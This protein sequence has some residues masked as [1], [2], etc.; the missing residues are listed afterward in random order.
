MRGEKEGWK[1]G[2][3]ESEVRN[4]SHE[5]E[6]RKTQQKGTPDEMNIEIEKRRKQA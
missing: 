6:A 2:G 5:D 1:D 3:E 4:K